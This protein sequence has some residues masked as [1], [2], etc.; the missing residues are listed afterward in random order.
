[1][2]LVPFELTGILADALFGPGARA[3]CFPVA[4]SSFIGGAAMFGE[5]HFSCAVLLIV[6]PLPIIP[7]VVGPLH[8]ALAMVLSLPKLTGI[9]RPI[10][11]LDLSGGLFFS[12]LGI[13]GFLFNSFLSLG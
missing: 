6:D 13:T 12:R 1:M 10:R 4:P 11:I 3:R 5:E 9:D 8:N 7:G 2:H